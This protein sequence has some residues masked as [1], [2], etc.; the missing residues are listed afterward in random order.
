[1]LPIV[2]KGENPVIHVGPGIVPPAPQLLHG[3]ECRIQEAWTPCP[4]D[5]FHTEYK[6]LYSSRLLHIFHITLP[7]LC[8]CMHAAGCG[9]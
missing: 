3:E 4:Q 2:T 8:W 9:W 6:I 1:M 5:C 7:W